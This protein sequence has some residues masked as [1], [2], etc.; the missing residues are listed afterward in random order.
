MT[1]KEDTYWLVL[2]LLIGAVIIIAGVYTN[3]L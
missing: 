2:V 3:V 1:I